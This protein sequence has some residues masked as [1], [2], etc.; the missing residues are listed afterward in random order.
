MFLHFGIL[1]LRYSLLHCSQFSRVRHRRSVATNMASSSS[2]PTVTPGHNSLERLSM[3]PENQLQC[4][5]TLASGDNPGFERLCSKCFVTINSS[6]EWIIDSGASH[7]VTGDINQLVDVVLINNR[8]TVRVPKGTAR[9][10]QSGKVSVHYMSRLC[11]IED[12]TSGRMIPTGESH[13]GFG[14]CAL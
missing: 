12:R 7:Y 14:T 10:T 13:G 9:A 5:L 1:L 11:L 6:V 4:L 3:L 8:P 2:A